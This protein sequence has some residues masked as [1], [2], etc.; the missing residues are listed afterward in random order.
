[1]DITTHIVAAIAVAVR[2]ASVSPSSSTTKEMP[3]KSEEA[4]VM[5]C[6]EDATPSTP[7]RISSSRKAWSKRIVCQ[8]VP[9]STLQKE[10]YG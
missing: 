2:L 8:L 6:S 4:T 10:G 7:P 9:R 5:F 3:R 1:M